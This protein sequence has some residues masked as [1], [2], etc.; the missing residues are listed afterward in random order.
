MGE[1]EGGKMKDPFNFIAEKRMKVKKWLVSGVLFSLGATL[2]TYYAV[3]SIKI[4]GIPVFYETI[5]IQEWLMIV[6][7][8]ENWLLMR[9]GVFGLAFL[10]IVYFPTKL[11]ER[12]QLF[13][14]CVNI[15]TVL[16]VIAMALNF[17]NDF[18]TII[19]YLL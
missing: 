13:R 19:S 11:Y 4:D 15:F 12:N 18:S 9:M 10:A 1:Y 8:M 2:L 6:L 17:W 14:Y 7:G 3:G 16:F 5:K